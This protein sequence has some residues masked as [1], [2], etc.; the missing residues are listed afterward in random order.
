M[1]TLWQDLRYGARMLLGKPGFTVIA[2]LTL[3]LGIGANTAIF[4]VVNSILLR[5]LPYQQ[6]ERLVWWWEVQPQLN[7]A[8]FS[9]ADFLD[10]RTQNETFEQVAGVRNT[11]LTITGSDQ[12]ERVR[13][14]IVTENFF[15]MLGVEPQLGRA[16]GPDDGRKGSPRVAVLSHS[17]WQRRFGGDAAVIGRSVRLSGEDV[18][19]IGVMPRGFRNPL[20]D[21]EIWVNPYMVVPDF[22]FAFHDDRRMQQRSSHYMKI[23]GRLRPGVTLT[24][25]QQDIASIFERI[26]QQFPQTANHGVNLV[27]LHERVTGQVQA[28]LLILLGAVTL[29]LLMTCANVANLMLARATSRAKEIAIRSALGARRGRLIRQL[30]TESVLVAILGGGA[31]WLLAMW[32]VNLLVSLSPPDMPRLDEIGIDLRVLGFTLG[33]SL[34]TGIIFGLAPAFGV[35]RVNVNETLKEGTRSSGSVVHNRTRGALVIAEMALALVVMVGA[36]LLVKSFIKLQSVEIGFNPDNLLTMRM[37]LDDPK[38]QSSAETL[39]FQRELLPK[40]EAIPGVEALAVSGD[41]PVQGTDTSTNVTVEAREPAHPGEELLIGLHPINTSYFQAMGIKLLRG[42][43]FTER[44]DENAPPVVIIN[45][46]AAERLWPGQDPVGKRL[47]FAPANTPNMQWMEV[48]GVVGDV[49]HDGLHVESG[50]HSYVPIV[51]QPWPIYTLALRSHMDSALLLAA[52]QQAVQ[53]VDPNQPFYEVKPMSALIGEAL[54]ERRLI[55]VLFGLFAVVALVLA[56]VGIYGVVAYL[57]AQRT[58]EIGVRVALGARRSDI[59][60]L[61]LKQGMVYAVVGAVTGVAGAIA[62]TRLMKTLLFEVAAT[63]AAT[64][65]VTA[66]LLSAMALLACYIPARRATR[67]DP[68]VA[69]RYE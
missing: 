27:P 20:Q 54:A 52:A 50:M 25:A 57:V 9:A 16:L 63:D 33:V 48:V 34:L 45:E 55:L 30:L 65:A 17:L 37:W 38:Y 51:Q 12:A 21:A 23:I 46:T 59:L 28:A 15:T 36:G 41:L 2:V 5:P 19:V 47:T 69:L 64:F 26:H 53:S 10:F 7:Q 8:P 43:A 14:A 18:T 13:A 58:H 56:A 44:D 6:P 1:Q 42:R 66:G 61:V 68:M 60:R 67:V 11:S 40:L 31:G 29:V 22:L 24:Q 39:R 32:G 49:K 62:V 3:A 4:S 35:S